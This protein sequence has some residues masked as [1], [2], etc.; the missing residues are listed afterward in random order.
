MDSPRPGS[1]GDLRGLPS[2]GGGGAERDPVLA[3]LL[4]SAIG[5]S[6][7]AGKWRALLLFGRN[8]PLQHAGPS[9]VE[10]RHALGALT[11][12]L[13]RFADINNNELK[14]VVG[15]GSFGAHRDT[16]APIALC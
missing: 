4:E 5:V 3:G 10:H 9:D 14:S 2:R 12:S 7:R 6:P 1:A 13:Q 11:D 16:V 8:I 15:K